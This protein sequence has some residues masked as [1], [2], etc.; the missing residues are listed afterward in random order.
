MAAW[1]QGFFFEI[2]EMAKKQEWI[3]TLKFA[4]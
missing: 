2:K 3:L 4:N 1:A